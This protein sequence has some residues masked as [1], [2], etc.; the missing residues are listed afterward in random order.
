M[1]HPFMKQFK[2]NLIK[3]ALISGGMAFGS[4]HVYAQETESAEID[5]ES[6]EV[7]Q[8]SGIRASLQRAQAIKMNNTSIVEAISAEDIGKLP[9]IS[10]AESLSRLP[11]LATQ[12]LNG[13]ANVISI[14]GLSE[15]FSTAMF[16]GRELVS[17]NDNRGIEFDLFPQEIINE[18]V[19]YKSADS[20]LVNQGIAGTIDLRSVKPLAHG[21][22]SFVVN[23]RYEEAQLGQLN[24]DIDDKGF[25]GG[26]TYIDQ[27][28]DDT[29]GVALT[30]NS[31]SSPVAEERWDAWGYDPREING[32][33][34]VLTI[35]GMKPF[36][37]SSEL[38]RDS[39]LGVV[40][41]APNDQ[42]NTTFDTLY[43][44]FQD[45]QRLR[46]VELPIFGGA[47]W[48][49]N[50]IED[51]TVEDGFAT[52][53][54][55]VAPGALIRNDA[56]IRDAEMIAVGNHTTYYL[57]D[58]WS[59]DLDLSY[60]KVERTDLAFESYAT[61]S[62][63]E[64]PGRNSDT[65]K[66]RG[67]IGYEL[68]P[69]N[70]GI[71]LDPA[72]DFS[73]Y[74]IIQLAN[75]FAWGNGNILPG[76]TGDNQDGFVNDV[77]V[78][79]ELSSLRLEATKVLEDGMFRSINFGFNYSSREKS[80]A[81]NASFLT[82]RDPGFP[83][84]S[85]VIRPQDIP[86]QYRLSPVSLDFIGMGNVVAY[87]SV[88][89]FNDGA[90]I[91]TAANPVDAGRISRNWTVEEDVMMI[92]AQA[93]IDTEFM[94]MYVTGNIGFQYQDIQQSSD[95]FIANPPE[96]GPGFP[97]DRT[98]NSGGADIS[99]F[100]PSIN[101]TFEVAEGHM[102]RFGAARTLSRSRMDRMN[103]GFATNFNFANLGMGGQDLS[104]SPWS[105]NGGNPALEPITADALDLSYE[106]YFSDDGY[107]AV[108]GFYR[109]LNSWQAESQTVVDFSDVDISEILEDR[110]IDPSQVPSQGLVSVWQN[111]GGG[112]FSGIELSGTIPF[113]IIDEVLDGAGMQFSA[114]FIDGEVELPD[115]ADPEQIPGQSE[116][117]YTA[118][119]FYERGG[120][121]TRLSYR[122]RDDFLA[123]VPNID[124]SRTART[125]V[126]EG[127]LD[128]QVAYDF[129]DAENE[130]LQGLT[131]QVQ[132]QNIT[133][134]PFVTILGGDERQIKDYQIYG[135]TLLAG[136][137]YK[138]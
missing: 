90:Y 30:L 3:A 42:F 50:G 45:D 10:I 64:R 87:D 127:I 107:L 68:L 24:P 43:V 46:G 103:A 12:R 92:F 123:E 9:G 4:A 31:M 79:D 63:D 125:A 133:D 117:I 73:D 71:Q 126:A 7:I 27:F 84:E 41:F 74:N 34:D 5:E 39:V 37:R 129:K 57:N 6:L 97:A 49:N 136:L 11:G 109:D 121:Q 124:L 40:E 135:R 76:G 48:A 51:V 29:L 26:F 18:V 1:G 131:L 25:R 61:F 99:E 33:A 110:G 54:N 65:D 23:A 22:Q 113:N 82:I 100:L 77:E 78:E 95:G 47:G 86:E 21:E 32:Q 35:G 96:Q 93:D 104:N 119:L 115:R 116:R 137:I 75:P 15:D 138:F 81:D 106:W 114:T 111:S 66:I 53:G 91:S 88:A 72:L 28:A 83:G 19:V 101:L 13:R 108:A 36:V 8:V 105:G 94:G 134:E 20:T 67:D 80:R 122:Y 44:D 70:N 60:S 17:I 118:A 62:T 16:N 132:M 128:A 120:F 69:G 59:I 2:P 85:D 102:V 130:A 14:R 55:I 89:L 56:T 38:R 98:P 112:H 58:S 52:A